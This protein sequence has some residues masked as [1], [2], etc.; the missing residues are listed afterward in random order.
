MLE[1]KTFH[2]IFNL[3]PRHFSCSGLWF[4]TGLV[5]VHGDVLCITFKVNLLI[6][7]DAYLFEG[8]YVAAVSQM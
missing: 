6:T 3:S 1:E 5:Q 7:S 8:L 2:K 4:S